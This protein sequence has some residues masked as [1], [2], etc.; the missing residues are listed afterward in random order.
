MMERYDDQL[1]FNSSAHLIALC[2]SEFGKLILR[3]G[4]EVA[5]IFAFLFS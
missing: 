4:R 5:G 2:T 3:A 1:L